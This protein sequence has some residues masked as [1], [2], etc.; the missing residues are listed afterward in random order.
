MKCTNFVYGAVK[1]SDATLL[2]CKAKMIP[3]GAVSRHMSTSI[4]VTAIVSKEM[5]KAFP[6]RFAFLFELASLLLDL[7]Y[8][9][10]E[11]PM[12]MPIPPRV[13]RITTG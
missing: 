1:N 3:M 5:E 4:P 12:I 2:K 9:R 8:I 11:V 13:P 10:P 7:M 6:E